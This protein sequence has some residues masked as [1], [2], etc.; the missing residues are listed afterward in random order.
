MLEKTTNNTTN[1]RNESLTNN[2]TLLNKKN[3]TKSVE[4]N[5]T[6]NILQYTR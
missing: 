2:I 5:M 4:K 6:P 1:S 3:G